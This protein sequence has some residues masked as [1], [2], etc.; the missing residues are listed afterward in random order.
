MALMRAD[1]EAEVVA[2][3]TEAGYWTDPNVWRFLGDNENNYASIGNQQSEAVAAL[4]EKVINGVDARL[5]NACLE[6][7][8]NPESQE[9]PT[10]IR[11]AVGR[12]F[13]G[14]VNTN[15]DVDGRVSAWDDAKATAEGR[16]LTVSATG[17]PP[18]AG[19]PSISIADQGEG[20]QPDRFP[21]TFLSLQ[22]KNKLRV[23]F[24]QGK[25]NMGGTG[26]L[27]FCGGHHKLQLIV[28]RRNPALVAPGSPWRASEWGF[29]V[30]KRHWPEDGSR[31][32]VFSYLAPLGAA[33][34]QP[35]G[36]LSF[37]AESW[38]IFPEANND[39]RDA[40]HRHAP[41]GSLVKLYE[42]ALPGS[43]SN[44]VLS[45]G[46]LLSRLD[47]GMPELAL[48]VRVFEC[49]QN[50]KGHAGSFATNVLG[51]ATRLQKDKKDNLEDGFPINTVIN[52]EGH[53]VKVRA[54]AF[55][56]QK[57]RDYRT[58]QGVL[59]AVNGQTHATF[60]LEFFRRKAV[61][62]SYLADALLVLV[63]CTAIDGQMREDLF[64]NSRD[65]LRDTPLAARLEH[66]LE[67]WLKEDN[68]L[69]ELRNRRR[70]QE[71]SEKLSDS[72]PLTN[73]L[74]DILKSSPTLA[75]LFLQGV[76]IS[77]PFP[78]TAGAGEGTAGEF[79]GKTYPTYFRFK[80]LKTGETLV[81]EAHL[82]TRCRVALETD[83]EDDYFMRELDPGASRL[84][85]VLDGE[86][87]EVQDWAMRGPRSG[88]GQL[89]LN[90]LPEEA[91]IGD[92][93]RYLLEITDPS[94]IDAFTNEFVLKVKPA[95]STSSGGGGKT[96]SK[97]AG[98]GSSGGSSTLQ[99][100]NIKE[101]H[102][103]EWGDH[104]G[105]NELTAL[106][107]VN[108]GSTDDATDA[109]DI[110]DFYINVDNKYLRTVQKESKVEPKLLQAKFVY[111]MVLVGLALLQDDQL[112]STTPPPEGDETAHAGD[113]EQLVERSTRALAPI[114]L[115]M[116]ETI[117]ALDVTEE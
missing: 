58:R 68:A 110:Y 3:L 76:K 32:S 11:E 113:A 87:V 15:P 74:Q 59:F 27:Q 83:A 25:F 94:R 77:S 1:T 70:A 5:L 44:I 50:Y 48:P 56:G 20:Q 84:L 99:L 53:Q 57:A 108:A 28:S 114:L 26:A 73:V 37:A 101:V 63:D 43:R 66:E 8:I 72:K 96:S 98:S 91:Q 71:L 45:G 51:L 9:A 46:G 23:H 102:E 112:A 79:H 24:V 92:E 106:R 64:M 52:L 80:G 116:L 29:T 41:Y 12:F 2:I 49:R 75:K 89:T 6:A 40:Y 18:N 39:V 30:V 61:Q 69:K 17:N 7:G 103:E 81:R 88:V 4:I 47:L 13:E 67:V 95:V 35:G 16:L 109:A 105:F 14:K 111:G 22:G 65:R 107:V 82:G 38:P 90:Q 55:K 62:M 117:G 104:P 78:P 21:D 31:S 115:P 10:S 85:Q 54:F 33:P 42:Y 93:L 97:N 19:M 34:G 100:P 36:V 60:P 86:E